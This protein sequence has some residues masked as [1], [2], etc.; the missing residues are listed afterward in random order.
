MDRAISVFDANALDDVANQE[1]FRT[2]F[3]ALREA[4]PDRAIS[5]FDANAPNDVANQEWFR[6]GLTALRKAAAASAAAAAAAAAVAAAAVPAVVAPVVPAVAAAAVPA[7][8]AAAAMP[9]V[10]AV[11]IEAAAAHPNMQQSL[12][13]KFKVIVNGKPFVVTRRALERTHFFDEQCRRGGII[14]SITVLGRDNDLFKHVA[15]YLEDDTLPA[16]LYN[17]DAEWWEQLRA[18]FEYFEVELPKTTTHELLA[19]G[20]MDTSNEPLNTCERYEAA[21]HAWTAG[22]PM[23]NARVDSGACLIGNN[24][25]VAGGDDDSDDGTVERFDLNMQQW[26][27]EMPQ[28]NPPRSGHDLCAVGGKVFAFGGQLS[29]RRSLKDMDS[30]C[31]TNALWTVKEPMLNPRRYFASCVHDDKI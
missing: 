24:V 20:G 11:K 19:I 15:Q 3:T 9:V 31:P 23:H 6:T 26:S 8:A 29:T 4:A 5:V 7:A 18:E 30:Y 17:A 21:T 1:W 28:L 10:A 14:G 13:E 25:Y 2:G 12:D 16:Q 22:A 27:A